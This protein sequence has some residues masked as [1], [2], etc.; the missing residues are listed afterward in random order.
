MY[1]ATINQ[2]GLILLNK[3]AREALGVKLGDRVTIN[4]TSRAAVIE[5]EL[6]DEDF[7]AKLDDLKSP[8]TKQN[9][10]TFAGQSADELF[11]LAIKNSTAKNPAIKNHQKSQK[12]TAK[13][14]EELK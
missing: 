6:S 11:E 7:F 9:L 8:K 13:N 14:R 10:R 12:P 4:F 5:K 3:A 2:N 1:T